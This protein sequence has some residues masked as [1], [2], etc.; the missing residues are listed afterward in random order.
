M[1]LLN[2]YTNVSLCWLSAAGAAPAAWWAWPSVTCPLCLP[3][4]AGG[5][6]LSRGGEA[7]V[8]HQAAGTGH[9][10]LCGACQSSC[11]HGDATHQR[12]EGAYLGAVADDAHQPADSA[13]QPA[14]GQQAGWDPPVPQQESRAALRSGN[15]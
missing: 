5:Q 3:T 4:E 7:A 14:D 1:T 6:E 13:H 11:F 8:P 2:L 10:H 12:A 15:H 9:R